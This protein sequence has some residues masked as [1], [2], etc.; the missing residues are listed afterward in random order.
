[1]SERGFLLAYLSNLLKGKAIVAA[2]A[3]RPIPPKV[4][5]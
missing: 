4:T 2:G 3:R 5:H 1:M